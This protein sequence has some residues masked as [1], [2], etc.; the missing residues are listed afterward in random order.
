[1]DRGARQATIKKIS[2]SWT[3][4]KRLST[5]VLPLVALGLEGLSAVDFFWGH[6]TVPFWLLSSFLLWVIN[7][8]RLIPSVSNA[9]KFPFSSGRILKDAF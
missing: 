7:F 2:K 3:W 4:L 5:H 6:L 1:M 9:E 8:L